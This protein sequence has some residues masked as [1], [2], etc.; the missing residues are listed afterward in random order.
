M[1]H[2]IVGGGMLD[3]IVKEYALAN[4]RRIGRS[5]IFSNTGLDQ[6]GRT[7]G[8]CFARLPENLLPM[9]VVDKLPRVFDQIVSGVF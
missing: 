2:S 1:R 5:R 8:L 3:R 6:T 9:G 4:T 7:A